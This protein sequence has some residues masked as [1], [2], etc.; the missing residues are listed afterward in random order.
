M[1]VGVHEQ[2]QGAKATT[3]ASTSS[4]FPRAEVTRE[5]E[6]GVLQPQDLV[7]RMVARCGGIW[8]AGK[9][10][11]WS[12]KPNPPD[13]ANGKWMPYIHALAKYIKDNGLQDRVVIVIWHEPEN[14]VPKFFKN[15][16]DFVRLFN[17]VQA[18]LFDVDPTIK[19]SHAALGYAYRNWAVS[20]AASWVTKCT[21]HSIDIYSGR[22]FPLS[23]TI[24]NSKAFQ[25]WKASRPASAPWG[26]SERGWIAD[27][28]RSEERVA[29]IN[30]EADYLA[31]L[32]PADQPDFYIVWNTEGTENDPTIILD[33]AGTG[34][35]NALFDRM[36]DVVCPCCKGT[37]RVPRGPN[38]A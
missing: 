18:W 27:E 14:D 15:A 16:A 8:Q 28:S 21:I 10:A 17:T 7:G 33:A 38:D 31:S 30:A 26:I 34:A 19:T 35:V 2:Y 23:M 37:G 6:S 5:F 12:F 24:A 36:A 9:T 4:R 25:T 29:S 11:V 3:F 32:A 20:Q 22:S 1:R 13:V